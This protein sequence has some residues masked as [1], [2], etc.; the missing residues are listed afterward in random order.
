MLKGVEEVFSGQIVYGNYIISNYMQVIC[1]IN[2]MR[3]QQQRSYTSYIF[4]FL[5]VKFIVGWLQLKIYDYNS[6]IL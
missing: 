6:E 2:E 3:L 5:L 4:R 1:K